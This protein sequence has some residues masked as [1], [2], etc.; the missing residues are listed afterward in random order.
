[1]LSQ[2]PIK[3]GSKCNSVLMHYM[4]IP[5]MLEEMH[6]LYTK[7]CKENGFIKPI[8]E[9]DGNLDSPEPKY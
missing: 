7:L 8:E 6:K 4:Y 2:R 1:M 9:G 3:A 5:L